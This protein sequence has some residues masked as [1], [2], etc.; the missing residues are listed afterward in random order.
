MSVSG[1]T[2]DE[3][4]SEQERIRLVNVSRQAA[5]AKSRELYESAQLDRREANRLRWEGSYEGPR[6]PR[7][8]ARSIVVFQGGSPGLGKRH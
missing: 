1:K 8:L 6:G 7:H 5:A 4:L 3:W 2:Q